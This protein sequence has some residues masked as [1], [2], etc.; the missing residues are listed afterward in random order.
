VTMTLS[1]TKRWLTLAS[2]LL[3]LSAM[4]I[5]VWGFS[6]PKAADSSE[7][8]NLADAANGPHRVKTASTSANASG[9]N[10]TIRL[11]AAGDLAGLLDRPL[12]RPLFDPPP[13]PAK[14]VE[15]RILPPI[16]ARLLAT[17]I[18]P[19]NSTAILKLANGE[20]VFR[21]VGQMLGTD[22]PTAKIARIEAGSVCVSREGD[23][24]H[25]LV[26][27]QKSR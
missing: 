23:E 25:L 10:R 14:I 13:P 27:G 5:L 26:D 3:L 15:K 17:M 18:E 19:D 1:A 16:R 2:F 9:T 11:A 6:S 7:S 22:E 20:V 12:R 8:H 21:K 4:G 24:M